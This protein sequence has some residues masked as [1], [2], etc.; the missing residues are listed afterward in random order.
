MPSYQPVCPVI[1]EAI[2]LQ[3]VFNNGLSLSSA[4]LG[5]TDDRKLSSQAKQILS[6]WDFKNAPDIYRA[7]S[8]GGITST[9]T[10]GL[11][12]GYQRTILREAL[13]SLKILDLIRVLIEPSNS[14]MVNVPYEVR[15]I[16]T[17]VNEGI[18]YEGQPIPSASITQTFDTVQVHATKLSMRL[19]NEVIT[20]T[21]SIL[22]WDAL[23][24]NIESNARL[25][26]EL[27]AMRT[28]NEIQRSADAYGAVHI[29]HEDITAQ[30]NG[31]SSLI[32]TAQW[33]IVRPK[34]HVD[35][36][37]NQTAPTENPITLIL[38]GAACVPYDGTGKQP[39]AIYYHIENYNMGFVRLV[40]QEGG[41]VTPTAS[42]VCTLSYSGAT[43]LKKFDLKA[44]AGITQEEHLNGLLQAIGARKAL[45]NSER[46]VRPD[47]LLM[48]ST[49]NDVCTNAKS[50]MAS[51]TR[52][53]TALS[54]EGDL[55]RIKSLPVFN[56]DVPGSDLGAE[57]ILMSSI[58]TC[59][60]IV[61][62]PFKTGNPFEAFDSITRRPTGEKIAY[63]EEYSAIHVPI[64]Y[65]SRMTSIIAFD[66]D[67][68]AS[69]I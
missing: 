8:D 21:G 46:F 22:E 25:L 30:L 67:A 58:D 50:F 26:K 32:K 18:V 68:R 48:S 54:I 65:R 66:P 40:D 24:R 3:E 27:T 5:L 29:S 31:S 7:L 56:T 44:P 64:P 69:A 11:P 13:A 15:N 52:P 57:R 61:V 59:S 45:M 23:A 17:I 10:I 4:R 53:G 55:E 49:L 42:G 19:T 63:G 16:G 51:A 20:F 14:P 37:Q 39:A 6:F 47:Y 41:P 33:P 1:P 60:Y 62:Q 43:N 34:I 28:I 2:K 9:Q 36:N 38:N 12:I 35:L